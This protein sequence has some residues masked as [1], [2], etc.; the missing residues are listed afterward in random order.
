MMRQTIRHRIS[1]LLQRFSDTDTATAPEE[2]DTS[3]DTDEDQTHRDYEND[4]HAVSTRLQEEFAPDTV[5][6]LGCGIGLHLQPFLDENIEVR[7]VDG[8]T[9]AHERAVIP[10]NRITIAD[11]SQPYIPQK[12]YDLVLCLDLLAHAPDPME[13]TIIQSIANAGE[14]AVVSPTTTEQ[15]SFAQQPDTYWINKFEQAGME[16]DKAA[17][18]RVREQLKDVQ[19]TP[20]N[21]LVFTRT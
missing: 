19:W 6:H 18:E 14:T 15:A 20:H 21:P 2:P 3:N 4:A 1:Q 11:L 13:D 10:T 9:I 7:G 17:T 5:I 8:S 12:K 16:Y